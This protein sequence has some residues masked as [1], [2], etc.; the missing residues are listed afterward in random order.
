MEDKYQNP[1]Q[2]A[3]LQNA[4]KLMEFL[5]FLKPAPIERYAQIHAAGDVGEDGRKRYSR[6]R[7]NLADYTAGTGDKLRSANFSL[8]PS[9]VRRLYEDSKRE[10]LRWSVYSA[11]EPYYQGMEQLA[12]KMNTAIVGINYNKAF[13]S[14]D[15]RLK[16]ATSALPPL[17]AFTPMVYSKDKIYDTHGQ[18]G[19][20]RCSMSRLSITRTPYAS[21][22]TPRRAPWSITVD[23]GFAVPL[24]NEMGGMYAK[25][26][27]FLSAYGPVTFSATDEDWLDALGKV[28]AFIE[29]FETAYC[30]RAIKDGR[31]KAQAAFQQRFDSAVQEQT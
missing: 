24:R 20:G 8:E 11:M 19:T 25:P 10:I 6:I 1:L 2:I 28:V 4:K 30:C 17:P 3:K 31:A 15:E 5:D 14:K 27:S 16:Q 9:T 26:G 21:D 7:L 29:C 18:P 22:G 13:F 12:D 23:N